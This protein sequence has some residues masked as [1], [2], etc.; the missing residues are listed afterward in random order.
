DPE[1]YR[2]SR[3]WPTPSGPAP[4]PGRVGTLS[5]VSLPPA[6]VHFRGNALGTTPLH[7]QQL[8]SGR[9]RLILIGPDGV[10]RVLVGDVRAGEAAAL[11][12]PVTRLMAEALSR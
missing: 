3:P 7:G 4:A 11:Q 10:R 12:L 1:R 8:P 6:Q 2:P 9:Q 5:L